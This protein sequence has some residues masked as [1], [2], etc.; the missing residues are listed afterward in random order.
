MGWDVQV[1]DMELEIDEY[2]LPE[3]VYILS[4]TKKAKL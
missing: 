2:D 4:V 3:T 1:N